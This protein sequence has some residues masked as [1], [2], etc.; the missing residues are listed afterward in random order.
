M[1]E[2]IILVDENDNLVGY[3]EKIRA[4]SDGGRLH[5]AFSVFIFNSKKEMLLQLRSNAKHH[6]QRLWT[7]PCCSHPR[8]DEG[9]EIAAH[10]RLKEEFGFDT[11]LK[12]VFS[13]TY[14]ATDPKSGLTE[15]EF[16][17]VFVGRFEGT[18]NPDPKEIDDWKWISPDKLREDLGKN[19]NRY[20]PWLRIA[21]DRVL[22]EI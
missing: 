18:P 22:K 21:F 10:R 16:D 15:H 1:P 12:E 3:E 7:N 11:Q 5:R 19:P 14:K 8:K 20:T 9:L 2:I 13:F 17:H 4:H 6:F